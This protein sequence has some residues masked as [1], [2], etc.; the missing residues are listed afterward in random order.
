M[1]ESSYNDVEASMRAFEGQAKD[2]ETQVAEVRGTL[3]SNRNVAC[4]CVCI[5]D[6]NP[7]THDKECA[8]EIQDSSMQRTTTW[9]S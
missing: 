1:T 4:V 2:L 9:S 8:G 5:G 3:Y 7:S 6:K